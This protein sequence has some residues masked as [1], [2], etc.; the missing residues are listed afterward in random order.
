M[1]RGVGTV[2]FLYLIL[3]PTDE[4][5]R[6]ERK[7]GKFTLLEVVQWLLCKASD[8][9]SAELLPQKILKGKFTSGHYFKYPSLC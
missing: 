7:R 6:K 3:V 2:G 1:V 9:N 8:E 5:K 4:K